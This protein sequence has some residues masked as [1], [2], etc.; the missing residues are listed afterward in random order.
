M[1]KSQSGIF[2]ENPISEIFEAIGTLGLAI[3]ARQPANIHTIVCVAGCSPLG[4][5]LMSLLMLLL[6]LLPIH[7]SRD[8]ATSELS[9]TKHNSNF[10]QTT[11]RCNT[12]SR[13]MDRK[14][15]TMRSS[16]ISPF[17]SKSIRLALT[18]HHSKQAQQSAKESYITQ[19][20]AVATCNGVKTVMQQARNGWL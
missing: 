3:V 19:M 13:L 10:E 15:T 20:E 18:I 11:A 1:M 2:K 7:Q 16:A 5:S 4:T 14:L 12:I 8:D 17:Y 9:V 6:L